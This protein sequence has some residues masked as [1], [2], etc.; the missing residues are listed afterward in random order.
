[1]KDVVNEFSFES[2]RIAL[3]WI[4]FLDGFASSEGGRDGMLCA[5]V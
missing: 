1:M 2:S 4:G 3:G 5:L